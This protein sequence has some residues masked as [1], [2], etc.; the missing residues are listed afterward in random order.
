MGHQ[1]QTQKLR[2]KR[3]DGRPMAAKSRKKMEAKKASVQTVQEIKVTSTQKGERKVRETSAITT[4]ELRRD[5]LKS[6]DEKLLHALRKKLRQIE[7]LI[8]K[9]DA[10]VE[11]DDAQID[12][13]AGL[14]D[15]IAEMQ[16]T[17][18]RVSKKS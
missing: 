2:S 11:L 18:A 1:A 12:K 9:Q 16:E 15:V 3:P 4:G 17:A 8:K 5:R 10:G 7:E 6:S 13:V 14:E